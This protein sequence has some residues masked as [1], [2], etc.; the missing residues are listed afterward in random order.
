MKNLSRNKIIIILLFAIIFGLIVGKYIWKPY[1]SGLTKTNQCWAQYYFLIIF[2]MISL[3]FLF[4]NNTKNN[5][6]KKCNC[7]N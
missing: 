6:N 4:Y 1:L 3:I 5:E 7:N 2:S